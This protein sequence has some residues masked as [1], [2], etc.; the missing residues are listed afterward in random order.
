L[1]PGSPA[2]QASQKPPLGEFHSFNT[3]ESN[4]RGLLETASP[5]AEGV[6][7]CVPETAVPRK[8]TGNEFSG[9]IPDPDMGKFA[10]FCQV[11]LQLAERTVREH[12][13]QIGR[14]LRT[15]CKD[16][17][18]ITREDVRS[19]LATFAAK[20]PA[21]RANVLKSLK[22]YFRDYLGRPK[23]VET[24][25][26]PK[27]E[28]SP[29]QVPSRADLQRFYGA[30]RSPRERAFFLL[31]ATSGLRK[32]EV[33]SL[34]RDD[35]DLEKR[36][37]IPRKK[38]GTRTKRTW[39][40]FFNEEAKAALLKYIET[41]I[42]DDPRLFRLSPRQTHFFETARLETG[43]QV[44]PQVLREFFACEMGRLGVSDRY[45][46]AFCGRIPHS[47]LARHYTDFSPERLKEI[48]DRAGLK[49]F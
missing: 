9:M 27:Q 17:K 30:I 49:I 38:N 1:N 42:D 28:F 26:F 41:R 12:V 33:L 21:T 36:M 29:K 22:V 47:V 4:L 7:L 34:N 8:A 13:W 24:F 16:P 32:N 3:N 6:L 23:V 5:A 11:D 43:L 39:V 20:A 10:S 44:T 46:D 48:Y 18:F 40:S 19:Y 35:V 15:I 14:F 2:S 31:C 37:I 45:V 25:R